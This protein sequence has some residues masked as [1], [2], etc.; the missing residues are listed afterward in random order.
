M[1]MA[2]FLEFRSD[3]RFVGKSV[4]YS[5]M[6][7]IVFLPIGLESSDAHYCSEMA[8]FAGPRDNRWFVTK[9]AVRPSIVDIT[10]SLIGH[11]FSETV[12]VSAKPVGVIRLGSRI[13]C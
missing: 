2:N 5:S 1:E 12:S 10:C 8:F 11:Q 13:N 3:R 9:S 7:G 4:V 6:V